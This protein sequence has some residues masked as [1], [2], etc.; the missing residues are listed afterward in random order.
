[1][2]KANGR[3]RKNRIIQLVEGENII[4]GDENLLSHATEFYKSLFGQ[5]ERSGVWINF[6][7]PDRVSEDEN[8]DLTKPFS[9]EEIK[10]IVFSLA[11]NKSPG[12]DGFPGNFISSFEI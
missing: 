6:D 8:E 3:K 9:F 5:S 12:P 2:N 7:F 10:D 1:M 11:H 4:E